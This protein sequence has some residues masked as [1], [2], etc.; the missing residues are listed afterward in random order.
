MKFVQI[1][2]NVA[3]SSV[4]GAG[5]MRINAMNAQQAD[6]FVKGAM[7]LGIN[8]FDTADCYSNGG[9]EEVLGGVF[10]RDPSVR[11]KIV[12]QTKCAI[13]DG[14]Y[15][16][17]KDHILEAVNGSLKRLKTDHVDILLLHRPDVLMEAEEVNEAFEQ[18]YKEGKVLSFG[19]SNENPMQMEYLQSGLQQR[20]CVDQVQLS[21]AHTP[22]IDGLINVNMHNDPGAMR[23]GGILPY[24]HQKKITVQAWSPMQK[25]FFEG[26]F[27]GSD[28]YQ[29]LNQKLEEI[30]DRYH[31]S[32][33]TI[34]YA[35]ILRLPGNVQVITGTTKVSRLES[36]A[37]AADIR[38]TREEWYDLYKSAGNI[39]P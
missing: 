24:C 4:I 22:M 3:P 7:E 17:S 36:A 10:E 1:H 29:A 12:L 20:L 8:F 9:S 35:W 28:E 26:T 2:E 18:L 25:G 30:A 31:V 27:I 39:L 15:D 11:S 33:D 21:L 13:H 37:K 34:A 23:D 32:V 16:F 14:L 19:V 6:T 5:C 38:L